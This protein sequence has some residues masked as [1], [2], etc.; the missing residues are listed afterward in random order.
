MPPE[1]L[2]GVMQARCACY[3][4]PADAAIQRSKKIALQ[5][6]LADTN[7]VSIPRARA[8]LDEM[9]ETQAEFLQTYT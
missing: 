3:E 6:L 4:L 7:T 9:F 2:R 1:S 5:C 8:C